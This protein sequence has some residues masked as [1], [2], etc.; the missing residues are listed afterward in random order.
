MIISKGID[1]LYRSI[2]EILGQLIPAENFFIALNDPVNETVH[3]PYFVDQYDPPPAGS[4]SINGLTGYVI[5][6]GRSLLATREELENLIRE[7]KVA[8][9]GRLGEDWLG[10]PLQLGGR[11]IG[12]MAVQ[13]YTPEI[14]YN[15]ND[16]E[17]LEFISTQVAQAIERLRLEEEIR[18]LSLT[19][20]LT[21]LYNRRGFI[22]LAE[23]E[24]KLARRAKRK[25]MLFF[26]DVDNLKRINDT[27]GH[28]Q[29]DQV[30]KEI[31]AILRICFREMDI[32]G[33]IG[34]DEFVVLAPDASLDSA[35]CVINRINAALEEHNRLDSTAY[36]LSFSLGVACF[37]PEAP[38]SINEMIAQAD[39]MMYEKKQ[40][41]KSF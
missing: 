40:A 32:L 8:L 15:R 24:M 28:L 19:D 35:D 29:G 4:V 3:F 38:K 9:S 20:E 23:Q 25:M 1:D 5:R 11:I 14:H 26:G 30:L 12:V 36:L 41:K 16:V 7:G 27:L 18:S 10:V 6:T 13:S 33:R 37:D 22:L 34:G 31:S 2:H 17:L 21:G 39:K